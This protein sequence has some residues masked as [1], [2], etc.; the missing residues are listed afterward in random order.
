MPIPFGN[1]ARDSPACEIIIRYIS[2]FV[3]RTAID[4]CA[5]LRYNLYVKILSRGTVIMKRKMRFLAAVIVILLSAVMLAACL[6]DAADVS[7]SSGVGR[8]TKENTENT[9]QSNDRTSDKN[10]DDGKTG[11][12]KP[13][14]YVDP[15]L[16]NKD[17]DPTDSDPVDG[18]GDEENKDGDKDG[19]VVTGKLWSFE[20]GKYTFNF[21]ERDKSGENNISDIAYLYGTTFEDQPN[22]WYPGKTSYDE[23]TGEVTY[24]WDRYQSTID[25]V[26]KY[27]A[28]YR[29]DTSRKVC[30]FTFDCGYEFGPTADILDTLKEKE[31]S[32]IFFL[33]GD[34][35]ESEYDLMKRMLDE[36]HIIGNHTMSHLRLTQISGEEFIKEHEDLEDIFYE[37]FPDAEPMI[38]CRPPYGSCNEY[39]LA[40]AQ[41]MGYHTVMWSYTYMDYDTNNQLPHD[42]ALAKL[43]SGLHPG[44]VY[45]FHTE[46][47][48]NAAILGEFIDWV[49]AQGYEIL[50]ICDIIEND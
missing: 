2:L 47:T 4:I 50:P 37:Q 45:L 33:T 28:I 12:D 7:D 17:D 36:G 43:K 1:M 22:D 44:A 26:N 49:R 10:D 3:K 30:Y 23:A 41:K 27:G 6:R 32:A 9:D 25:A 16:D 34:Y 39:T 24:V 11:T 29:G 14:D 38:F 20:N 19:E 8:P 15:P 40:L 13:D 48:T 18:D 42:E 5:D 35:V 46:S 31:V 21:P